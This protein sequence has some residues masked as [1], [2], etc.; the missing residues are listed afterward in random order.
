M[1]LG[2][3]DL[4]R[5]MIPRIIGR[6]EMRDRGTRE[7]GDHRRTVTGIGIEIETEIGI[8][9]ETEIESVREK[10]IGIDIETKIETET[11]K[12]TETKTEIEIVTEIETEIAIEI[13]TEIG[14]VTPLQKVPNLSPHH[15][16]TIDR[17]TQN[18]YHHHEVITPPSNLNQ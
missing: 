12:E 1:I 16:D 3:V 17:R 11:V 7:I 5:G 13:R 18:F 8:E 2:M 10:G 4:P 15:P 14:I 9:I 6:L